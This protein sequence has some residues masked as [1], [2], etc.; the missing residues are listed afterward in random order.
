M[1][2]DLELKKGDIVLLKILAC[3]L[4]IFFS[5]RF[6]IL[7]G[8]E[9][10]QTLE[11]ER[12]ELE[13]QQ[14]DMQQTIDSAP[15]IKE[16]IVKQKAQLKETSEGYYDLMENQEMDELITGLILKHDL[17][18]VYLNIAE[19]VPGIPLSYYLAS[20]EASNTRTLSAYEELEG[21]TE[22]EAETTEDGESVETEAETTEDGESVETEAAAP[23]LQYTNTTSVTVTVQGDEEDIQELLDDIAK[24]YPGIQARSFE[25]SSSTYVDEKLRDVEQMN[26]NCV[27]AVYTCGEIG[28][29]T[30]SEEQ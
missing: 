26:C 12:E 4:I 28:G 14:L 18:P 9:K 10:H 27:F 1:K 2:L 16:K 3:V 11:L 22:T 24:N 7:P 6:L 30:A 17:F 20:V 25:M 19:P 23:F 29:E 21:E 13:A 15:F 8:I 5:F